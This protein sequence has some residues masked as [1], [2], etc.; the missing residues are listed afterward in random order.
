MLPV[1]AQADALLDQGH[2]YKT[3]GA[4]SVGR[5]ETAGRTLVVKRYNIKNLLHWCKRFW[6][7]SRAWHSWVEGNRLAFLGIATPKPLALL[8]RRFLW[9]RRE[10]YLVTEFLPGPDMLERFA[11]YVS[12]GEVPENELLALDQLFADLIGAR[13]S[14]GDFKGHNLFWHEQRWALIDLDAMCQHYS[15]HSFAAAYARDRARLLRNWPADSALHQLLDQRL[16]KL[17]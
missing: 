11:P 13:I 6:R 15:Q 1:L 7:P 12:T 17:D 9:L 10:A 8:E 5:V 4:A 14:H 3:G 16:P 2:L